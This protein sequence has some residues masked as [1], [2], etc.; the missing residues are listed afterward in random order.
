MTIKE[1]YEKYKDKEWFI[2]I[3]DAIKINIDHCYNEEVALYD[4]WQAIKTHVEVKEKVRTDA[5]LGESLIQQGQIPDTDP[6]G[7]IENT[8]PISRVE[9]C[10]NEIKEEGTIPASFRNIIIN[11]LQSLLNPIQEKKN[12]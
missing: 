5:H 3:V 10:I 6:P 9:E 8:I 7:K 1:V 11:K 12:G 2:N 4:L